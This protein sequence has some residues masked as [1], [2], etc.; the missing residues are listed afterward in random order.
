MILRA[1]LAAVV[2]VAL[3]AVPAGAEADA[4]PQP[5][6]AKVRLKAFGS[7]SGLVR[8]ARRNATRTSQWTFL[9]GGDEDSAAGEGGGERFSPTNVQEQG[10]DEPDIVKTDGAHAFAIAG[11]ALHS[12]DVQAATPVV[13]DSLELAENGSHALLLYGDRALVISHLFG[14]NEG[15]GMRGWMQST[16]LVEVDVSDPSR[17]RGEDARRRGQLPGRA[18]DRGHRRIVLSRDP[19]G[20]N[21]RA[22]LRRTAGQVGAARRPHQPR[23][24]R[25]ADPRL[26]ACRAVRRPAA[27]SGVEMMTVLT[28]DLERG[29]PAVDS[30]ALMTGADTSTPRRAPLCRQPALVRLVRRRTTGRRRASGPSIHRFELLAAAGTISAE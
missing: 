21:T 13:L 17:L 16:R 28:V 9:R 8:Y 10:V 20:S 11:S 25:Q 18:A 26:V 5:R 12:V 15:L 19:A 24:G 27:F 7:C 4:A 1:L 2:A 14:R 30:D 22:A 6:A 29:L 23:G 3:I